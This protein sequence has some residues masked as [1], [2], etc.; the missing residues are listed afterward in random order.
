MVR[1]EDVYGFADDDHDDVEYLLKKVAS[2][3]VRRDSNS[4][5]DESKT[6]IYGRAKVE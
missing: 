3:I 2:E 1:N 4:M 6:V 5:P